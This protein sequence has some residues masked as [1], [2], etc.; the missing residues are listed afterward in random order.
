MSITYRTRI[1]LKHV[2]LVMFFL[3]ALSGLWVFARKIPPDALIGAV[4]SNEST[5][6][7]VT[8]WHRNAS[9]EQQ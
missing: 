1:A 5:T 8:R 3:T 4:G 7:A 2:A 6:G 9:D